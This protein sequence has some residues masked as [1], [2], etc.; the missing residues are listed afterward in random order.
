[1]IC[2]GVIWIPYLD[3]ISGHCTWMDLLLDFP[4]LT[5][6]NAMITAGESFYLLEISILTLFK[7]I[8]MYYSQLIVIV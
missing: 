1:M 7:I 2:G 6:V 8:I 4:P 5:Y 3:V